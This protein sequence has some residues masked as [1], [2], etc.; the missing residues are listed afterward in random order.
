MGE[1]L[2]RGEACHI[3]THHLA[4]SAG[5]TWHLL[6]KVGGIIFGDP[7]RDS[8]GPSRLFK[9][10]FSGR[11]DTTAWRSMQL[12]QQTTS[13]QQGWSR[14]VKVTS[15]SCQDQ[16]CRR[17]HVPVRAVVDVMSRLELCSSSCQGQ[18]CGH[19]HDKVRT[20]VMIMSRSELQSWLCQGQR[21][22]PGDMSR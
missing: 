6:Q 4:E 13:T 14:Q 19:H 22:S 7:A 1:S 16:S 9:G 10:T 12:E 20:V 3:Y 21:Y 15:R 18:S 5:V 17:C 11:E 2:V 8:G